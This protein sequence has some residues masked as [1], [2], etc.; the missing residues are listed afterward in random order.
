MGVLALGLVYDDVRVDDALRLR[1][2]DDG[3]IGRDHILDVLLN[4]YLWVTSLVE[5]II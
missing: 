3:H 2:L 1:L 4:S 5:V